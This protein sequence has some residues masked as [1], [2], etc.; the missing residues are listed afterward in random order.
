[1][2]SRFHCDR[3]DEETVDCCK[4]THLL[5]VVVGEHHFAGCAFEQIKKGIVIN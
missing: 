2:M 4:I 3:L 5:S 1:M